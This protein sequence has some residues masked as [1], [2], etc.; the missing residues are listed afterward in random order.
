MKPVYVENGRSELISLLENLTSTTICAVEHD[1]CGMRCATAYRNGQR[2]PPMLTNTTQVVACGITG[3]RK[4]AFKDRF[5]NVGQF[6]SNDHRLSVVVLL[7][8]SLTLTYSHPLS[9]RL[10]RTVS[11]RLVSS[12]GVPS[13]VASR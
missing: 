8:T 11:P 2:H 13:R 6:C 1:F 5:G 4:P 10:Y 3:C 9:V 7:P 12:M